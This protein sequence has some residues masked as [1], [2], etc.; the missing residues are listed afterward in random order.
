MVVNVAVEDFIA[1]ERQQMLADANYDSEYIIGDD[2]A[3]PI[4]IEKLKEKLQTPTDPDYQ[5][6][7][8]QYQDKYKE[9]LVNNVVSDVNNQANYSVID[10]NVSDQ[11][12]NIK[13]ENVSDPTFSGDNYVLTVS[14]LFDKEEFLEGKAVL[15]KVKMDFNI[16]VPSKIPVP[17]MKT[18]R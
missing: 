3:G 10:E 16:D 2:P 12:P 18:P 1:A 6:W 17:S 4:N 14:S 5:I 13:V 11:K 15:Q 7:L 8:S 9:V